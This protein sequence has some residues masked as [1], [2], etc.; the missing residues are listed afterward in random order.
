LVENGTVSPS[1][2]TAAAA[3]PAAAA[4]TGALP[5]SGSCDRAD[6]AGALRFAAGAAFCFFFS[7]RSGFSAFD[8][9]AGTAFLDFFGSE[10]VE[11]GS[12]GCE[13]GP[14]EG[15]AGAGSGAGFGRC[16]NPG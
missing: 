9:R 1:E 13:V 16:A 6:D 8:A 5:G 15:A 7:G 2:R 14:D 12:V 10:T 4:R 11:D 3:G